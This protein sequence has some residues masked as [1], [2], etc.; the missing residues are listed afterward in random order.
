MVPP[1]DEPRR[2]AHPVAGRLPLAGALFL[3]LLAGGPAAA[4]SGGRVVIVHE[5]ASKLAVRLSAELASRGF[6]PVTVEEE[7]LPE[8]GE[9]QALAVDNSALAVMRIRPSGH[10]VSVWVARQQDGPLVTQEVFVPPDTPDAHTVVALKAVEMLRASLLVLPERRSPEPAP[11]PTPKPV[12]IQ[13]PK[14]DRSPLVALDAQPTLTYGFGELPPTLQ[15]GVG[16]RIRLGRRLR[17]ALIGLIPTFPMDLDVPEGSAEIKT[18]VLAAA[19]EVNVLPIHRS[20]SLFAG[21]GAGPLFIRMT[22]KADAPYESRNDLV[23]SILPHLAV[24]LAVALTKLLHLRT[25]L[26]AGIALP[27][28]KVAVL[29]REATS[30]GQPVLSLMFGLEVWVF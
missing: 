5:G 10:S 6:Q 30:W 26:C 25:D 8:P 3:A 7:T 13:P 21:A 16:T 14:G 27:K 19:L 17:L 12:A 28:P 18:G 2:T 24:S 9:L 29:D 4:E 11:G 1:T 22:G 15:M 20:V 23:I